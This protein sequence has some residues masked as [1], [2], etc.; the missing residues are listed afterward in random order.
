MY[1]CFAEYRILPEFRDSYLTLSNELVRTSS[2]ALIVYEGTD[3]PNLFVELW[4][5]DCEEAAERIKRE[6]CS[7]RSPWRQVDNWVQGGRAKVHVWTFR[8]AVPVISRH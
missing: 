4:S 2:D 3:Q 6:R 8:P 1:I 7:E 5:A